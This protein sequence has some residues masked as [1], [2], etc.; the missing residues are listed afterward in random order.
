MY[1]NDVSPNNY[2]NTKRSKLIST[3]YVVSSRL[4]CL[5]LACTATEHGEHGT[6]GKH[7]ARPDQ[8]AINARELIYLI[9]GAV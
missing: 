1:T 8:E 4:K 9:F 3:S 2:K 5:S 7:G 6:H